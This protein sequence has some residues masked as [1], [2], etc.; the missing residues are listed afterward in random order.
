MYQN[1]SAQTMECGTIGHDLQTQQTI[2][3]N[4][5]FYLNTQNPAPCSG[6]V[7]TWEYCYYHPDVTADEYWAP[8]GVYRLN[9]EGTMYEQVSTLT[10]RFSTVTTI[11][12]EKDDL[13]EDFFTCATFITPR[14]TIQQGDVL[15]T[16]VHD[17]RPDLDTRAHI[18]LAG[19]INAAGYS[20]K[21]IPVSGRD[22]TCNDGNTIRVP[23][24]VST[25]NL[26]DTP[27]TVLHLYAQIGKNN[28]IFL[29][30]NNN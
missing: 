23:D 25:G 11:M 26:L 5:R 17:V 16:C 8:I 1:V 29:D 14:I 2:L 15:G 12:I 9:S 13:G 27:S 3:T 20:L 7:T 19:N 18:N 21:H 4:L 28:E 10:S 6:N 24:S 30:D 22:G